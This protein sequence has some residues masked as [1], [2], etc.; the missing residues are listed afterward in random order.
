MLLLPFIFDAS[1]R[2]PGL[3]VAHYLVHCCLYYELSHSIIPDHEF[4]A[5]ARELAER[6]DEPG[7]CGHPH[8][9]LINLA[10]LRSGGSG[11]YLQYPG[12]VR[13]CAE[14][15]KAD[16]TWAR[17]PSPIIPNPYLLP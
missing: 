1:T 7:I 10:I 15:L 17:L 11:F 4:D 13:S 2:P 12:I 8:A 16:P 14:R 9:R 6:W 5:L 3:L